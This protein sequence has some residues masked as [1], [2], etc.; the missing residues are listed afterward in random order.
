MIDSHFHSLSP[1]YAENGIDFN[2]IYD[3]LS[4]G[5]D[6]ATCLE[7]TPLILNKIQARP[8]IFTTLG[9]GP[10]E[11]EGEWRGELA[12]LE[13]SAEG[14]VGSNKVVA[15]GEIGLDWHYDYDRKAQVELFTRQIELAQKLGL[16]LILHIRNAFEEVRDILSSEIFSKNSLSCMVHSFSSSSKEDA[17]FFLDRGFYLS[18]SALSIYKR[19]EGV[20]ENFA[21]CPSDRILLETDSPYLPYSR[22]L[23]LNTPMFVPELAKLLAPDKGLQAEELMLLA[24]E[25]LGRFVKQRGIGS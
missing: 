12:Q 9:I 2:S 11:C 13:E 10:W 25:N 21:Y 14:F 23:K 20:R 1:R 18:F 17:K 3:R 7:D 24:K 22:K 5:I 19:N 8:N 6:C 15:V 16:P 4:L